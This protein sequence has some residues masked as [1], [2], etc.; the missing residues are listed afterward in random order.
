MVYPS[1]RPTQQN[2]GSEVSAEI[3]EVGGESQQGRYPRRPS[4]QQPQASTIGGVNR[5]AIRPREVRHQE[6]HVDELL[7]PEDG[8]RR[9]GPKRA[10]LHRRPIDTF[11]APFGSVRCGSRRVGDAQRP[12]R[13]GGAE[14]RQEERQEWRHIAPAAQETPVGPEPGP[15]I[16]P[17]LNVPRRKR[18]RRA[19]RDSLPAK[20]ARS[21]VHKERTDDERKG[22]VASVLRWL[23]EEFAER[24]RLF[25]SKEWCTPIPLERKVST[26]QAFYRA[27]HDTNAL[28]IS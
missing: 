5:Q 27:F 12:T 7:R 17:A 28:P 6:A 15:Q 8:N 13:A 11:P 25:Y 16:V 23:D 20:R 24:E 10:S 1:P 19:S 9:P 4:N 21:G 3:R 18:R 2:P 14:E 22:D 26:I